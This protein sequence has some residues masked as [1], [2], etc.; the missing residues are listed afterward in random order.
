MRKFSVVLMVLVVSMAL[1]SC[2]IFDAIVDFSDSLMDKQIENA[3]PEK[4]R[5]WIASGDRAFDNDNYLKADDFYVR[6]IK[7]NEDKDV[8]T[9]SE[10]VDIYNSRGACW[11]NLGYYSSAISL[12]NT[13]LSYD[14]E[15]EIVQRN[16]ALT[17]QWQAEENARIAQRQQEQAAVAAATPP[18][19]QQ[20]QV[21]VSGL[22]A[23]ADALAAM[24]QAL[25]P[26]G[27]QVAQAPSN[28]NTPAQSTRDWQGAYNNN[29]RRLESAISSYN[30]MTTA[31]GRTGQLQTIRGYQ[32]DLRDIRS[33]ARSD[34]VTVAVSPLEN[35]NP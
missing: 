5:G 20:Q 13:A 14:P 29:V 17:Q 27:G 28:Q 7:A 6:A 21:D 35:W 8:L 34:G 18:Q 24:G 23:L 25:Q 2:V 30:R 33:Q 10:L 4:I 3:S 16:L 32:R 12:F 1:T 9:V 19:Q 31:T 15:N 22:N 26:Q 11:T